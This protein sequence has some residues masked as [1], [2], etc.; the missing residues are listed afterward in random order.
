M[1]K[2]DDEEEE[3]EETETEIRFDFESLNRIFVLDKLVQLHRQT[4]VMAC[5][6]NW[7]NKKKKRRRKKD[8]KTE[9]KTWT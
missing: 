1:W 4:A 3:E 7:E 9:E 6:H 8:E 5:M 2:N